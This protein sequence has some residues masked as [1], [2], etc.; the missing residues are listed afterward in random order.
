MIAAAGS[1]RDGA[2]RMN[3]FQFVRFLEDGLC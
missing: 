3:L 1:S 2:C